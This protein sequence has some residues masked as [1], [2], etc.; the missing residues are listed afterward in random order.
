MALIFILYEP[1]RPDTVWSE[2]PYWT[3]KFRILLILLFCE[4]RGQWENGKGTQ[5]FGCFRKVP[6]QV[7]EHWGIHSTGPTEGAVMR[8]WAN[9]GDTLPEGALWLY[10]WR[11]GGPVYPI[12]ADPSLNATSAGKPS[13]SCH[14]HPTKI[15]AGPLF[16]GPTAPR[17]S[18]FISLVN[19]YRCN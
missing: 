10:F 15:R 13:C 18:T 14:P 19:N 1:W 7:Q 9:K 8:L 5:N 2:N 6:R 17:A 16:P 11:I 4:P 3:R 12:K